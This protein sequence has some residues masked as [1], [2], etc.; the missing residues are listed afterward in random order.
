MPIEPYADHQKAA[1]IAALSEL[2]DGLQNFLSVT[3]PA[4]TQ[5]AAADETATEA[6]S[7]YLL[8][9]FSQFEG[10]TLLEIPMR[11]GQLNDWNIAGVLA[12]LEQWEGADTGEEVPG[13]EE[14]ADFEIIAPQSGATYQIGAI[15]F[16]VKATAGTL[17]YVTAQQIG[18]TGGPAFDLKES[19]GQFWGLT[20]VH[21]AG[22]YTFTITGSFAGDRPSVLKDVSFT[23]ADD[24]SGTPGET[25]GDETLMGIDL[26]KKVF[27]ES[28]RRVT[29]GSGDVGE[30]VAAARR[31]RQAPIPGGGASGGGG[32][33]DTW[34][35]QVD[36]AIAA[37]LQE[38]QT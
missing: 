3:L 30:V 31:L 6:L 20:Y 27:D 5:V 16:Q 32:A 37:I 10:L 29:S 33:S 35:Q 15:R 14:R 11:I 22:S 2:P 26:L 25:G 34:G 21:E 7:A 12:G 1:L 38:G 13:S 17:Q 28:V 18:G 24:G 8:A 4:V 36:T 23:I 9:V 19:N